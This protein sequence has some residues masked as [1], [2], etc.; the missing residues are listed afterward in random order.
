VRFRLAIA[1]AALSMA[2]LLSACSSSP[3]PLG[4][5]GT[6]GLQ[7]S[8]YREGVPFA[9]GFYDLHNTG[10]SPVTVTGVSVP[11]LH[12]LSVVSRYWLVP[13][14]HD[15]K[16]GNW[17]LIGVGFPWPP[18]YS[19][20]VRSVWAQ[21]KPAIGAVIRPGQDLNLVFA[22]IRTTAGLGHSRGPLITYTSGGSSYTMQFKT[23]LQ[24]SPVDC[25]LLPANDQVIP[26]S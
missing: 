26:T 22:M 13:V 23:F 7:C 3:S 6:D 2:A 12:G 5:G 8:P 19:A 4:D 14:Y 9:N 11:S 17:V 24:V 15:P 16:N 25:G 10:S 18:T 20:A 1:L 21:R